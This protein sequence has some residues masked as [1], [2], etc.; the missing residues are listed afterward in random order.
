MSGHLIATGAGVKSNTRPLS[1]RK[2]T[3]RTAG[4]ASLSQNY[5]GLHAHLI[6]LELEYDPP[7]VAVLQMWSPVALISLLGLARR[8]LH[9][10]PAPNV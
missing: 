5:G 9:T 8:D 6:G 1:W 2:S 10:H 4:A 7:L 3:L